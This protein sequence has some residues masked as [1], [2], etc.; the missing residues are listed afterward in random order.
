MASSLIV[1]AA[2]VSAISGNYTCQANDGSSFPM[3]IKQD[4]E[5][6]EQVLI[7]GGKV[8]LGFIKAKRQPVGPASLEPLPKGIEL[9]V[10]SADLSRKIELF[11]SIPLRAFQI[12][13][14]GKRGVA[15]EETIDLEASIA[16]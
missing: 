14:D 10:P 13:I 11:Y 5:N 3:S 12:I 6:T 4:Q 8:A 16:D 1:A 2:F 9:W 7:T 15:C